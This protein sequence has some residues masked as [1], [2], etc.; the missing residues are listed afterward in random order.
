VP[1]AAKFSKTYL[2][3]WQLNFLTFNALSTLHGFIRNKIPEVK[4]FVPSGFFKRA[5]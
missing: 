4:C 3:S 2:I 1:L 5:F